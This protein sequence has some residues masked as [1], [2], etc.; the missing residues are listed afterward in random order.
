M[1]K[2]YAVSGIIAGVLLLIGAA[3]V[4]IGIACG[5][6]REF[7]LFGK[8][9]MN[10][11]AGEII[12]QEYTRLE[13]FDSIYVDADYAQVEIISSDDNKYG[14]EYK[15]Y[16]DDTKCD[17]EDGRLVFKEKRDRFF[18]FNFFFFGGFNDETYIRIYVPEEKL[19]SIEIF[20]DMGSVTLDDVAC[21]YLSVDCDMGEAILNNITAQKVELDCD[22][23]NAE[24]TGIVTSRLG[25]DL[26]MGN[27][28]ITG[29]LD[30]DMD[31]NCDM[32][33][34]DIVSYY[35]SSAY[36]LEINTDMGG[37]TI[38]RDGGKEI[39]SINRIDADCDMGNINITFTDEPR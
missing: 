37:H 17:V 24:I 14:I 15:I 28:E 23:G 7:R 16:S 32:G 11:G 12:E 22:M 1:K 10:F 9:N 20:A 39:S 27:A 18:N 33:N 25:A 3:L 34:I 2:F 8:I 21:G 13:E 38:N 36:D 31:I 4:G 5:A 19:K 29:W 26:D 6:E 35:N 30:C